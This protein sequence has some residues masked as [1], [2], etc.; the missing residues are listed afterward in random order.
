MKRLL[1]TGSNSY[2]GNSLEEWMKKWR[3][4]YEVY[5]L[6]VK[7][8]NW[9]YHD[10]SKYDVLIH[11]AGIAHI[12]ETKSNENLYYK[13][14]RDLANEVAVKAKNEGVSQF[15][16]ISTMSVYGKET[17]EINEISPLAPI[18]HYGNSKL[19]A[20]KLINALRDI[21]FKVVIIRPPMIYG[22]GCKG[23]YQ[24]LKTISLFSPFFPYIENKRSM[25]YIDN[26][27]EFIRL[28]I[29][30]KEDSLYCPQNNEYIKT[31]EMVKKIAE[32]H[33]KSILFT[34]VFNPIISI[35]K[36]RLGIAKKLFGDLIYSK[37]LS[38]YKENYQIINF[39]ES[40]RLSEMERN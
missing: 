28:I 5:K 7:D 12:K 17:G 39:K 26:L 9:K 8:R 33:N 18:T 22:K 16:F 10:F 36:M 13:I 20:E 15:V 38:A 34:K 2:I 35:L 23:N 32:V 19:Q 4:E 14:N 31:S 30:N 25:I 11:V 29:K 1:I 37:H 27:C 6:S 3:N 24:K 21:N 40:I